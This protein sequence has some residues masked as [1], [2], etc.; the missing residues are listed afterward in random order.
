MVE[1]SIEFWRRMAS[2]FG[3]PVLAL[4][5]GA[6]ALAIPIAAMSLSV[7]GVDRDA[8]ALARAAA[9]DVDVR[10]VEADVRNLALPR[11]FGLVILADGAFHAFLAAGEQDALLAAVRRHL[12]PEGVF[13]FDIEQ[14]AGQPLAEDVEH[15]LEIAGFEIAA[16]YGD[17]D[18]GRVRRTS[19]RVIT[20]CRLAAAA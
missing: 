11:R 1:T 15:L 10:W 18:F 8:A 5:C 7:T 17:W 19:E 16:Q 14:R 4:C 2:Q 9:N 6:G 20:L 3:G 12:A 13:G